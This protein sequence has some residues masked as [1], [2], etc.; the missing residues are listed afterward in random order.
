M[1]ANSQF[2]L[3]VDSFGE[4]VSMSLC[5]TPSDCHDTD[6]V[7]LITNKQTNERTNERTSSIYDV[8]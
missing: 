6:L 2:E 1:Q 8:D 3:D 4:N 7:P 5:N